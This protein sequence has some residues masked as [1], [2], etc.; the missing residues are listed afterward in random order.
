MSK[1]DPKLIAAAKALIAEVASALDAP[2]AVELWDGSIH[3]LGQTADSALAIVITEPGVIASILKR[4]SLDRI[5]SHYAAG[6]LALKGGSLID[7]GRAVEAHGDSRRRL[8]SLSKAKVAR[9]L[10]PFLWVP[11]TPAE[12]AR[13]YAGNDSGTGR[14]KSENKDFVSFHYD[15]SN[16]FYDLFL[17][18]EMQYSCAYY[19]DWT[20]GLEQAQR[21]KLDMICRKLRLKPGERFL[22]IGCGW[23]GLVCHAAEHYGA[24]AH[25]I[26]L[27]E[28][29][30]ERA[31]ERIVARGLQD[32][33]NVE[34]RDFNDLEGRYDKIASIGMYEHIGLA[35]RER[36]FKT[37]RRVMAPDGLFLNHA[38]SRRAKRKTQAF[39]AR[40]EQRALQKYIF[41]GGE[42]DDIGSTLRIM[43]QVGF[44]VHDVEGWREHYARTT[45]LWCERL[46][47][48]EADAIA[49]VG[50]PTYRIWIAYLAGCSLAF[51]RGTARIFQTLVSYSAKQASPL[52]PTRADLYA[53]HPG[54]A[55]APIVDAVDTADDIKPR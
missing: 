15:V 43:E 35:S 42:L 20:N 13:S 21:D 55:A 5:I 50:A 46:M 4:P 2:V 28:R 11:S 40:A 51:S 25:G 10:M 14:S 49:L 1:D 22:D 39:R 19:T 53:P 34:I 52:P 31:R 24:I 54:L 23:G 38:I 27:S 45:A 29:Q 33:V 3:P 47:A 12:D 48:R 37:V 36:Y 17:D 9:L 18:P 7:L 41:P 32:R 44:E 26:T 16:A 30:L 6:K 8:Q